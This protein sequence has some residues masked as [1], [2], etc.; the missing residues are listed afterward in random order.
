MIPKPQKM[1]ACRKSLADGTPLNPFQ[2]KS[3]APSPSSILSDS[4]QSSQTGMPDNPIRL[5]GKQ[6][7]RQE[8][9]L[10][11]AQGLRKL[12]RSFSN[13]RSVQT[14]NQ[15]QGEPVARRHKDP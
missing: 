5:N 6:L 11:E 9:F 10:C 13:I 7:D 8:N 1:V 12:I 15:F 14:S 3:A 2:K 4:L